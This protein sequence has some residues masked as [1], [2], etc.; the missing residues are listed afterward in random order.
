MSDKE[1]VGYHQQGIHRLRFTIVLPQ[2]SGLCKQEPY[3]RQLLLAWQAWCQHKY[4]KIPSI[5]YLS[6]PRCSIMQDEFGFVL[7]QDITCRA[8]HFTKE[9]IIYSDDTLLDIC[10]TIK[11]IQVPMRTGD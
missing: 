1:Y 4:K 3:K 11:D 10:R 6:N 5:A 8:K 7:E 2:V 9:V